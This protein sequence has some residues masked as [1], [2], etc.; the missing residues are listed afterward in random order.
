[1]VPMNRTLTV[2]RG[3]P[4]KDAGGGLAPVTFAARL[5]AV[6][7]AIWPATTSVIVEYAQRRMTATQTFLTTQDIAPTEADRIVLDDGTRHQVL[8]YQKYPAPFGPQLYLTIV[9]T[10]ATT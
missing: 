9:G 8:G 10:R 7:C 5:S 6:P 1:M 4:T 3:A 2:E